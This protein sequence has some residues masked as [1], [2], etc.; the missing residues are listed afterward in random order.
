MSVFPLLPPFPPVQCSLRRRVNTMGKILLAIV[1]LL[2]LAAGA[3]ADRI[4]LL[5]GA[6]VEGEIVDRDDKH[7]TVRVTVG[8]RVATRKFPVERIHAITQEEKREVLNEMPEGE[9]KTAPRGTS[10]KSKTKSAGDHAPRTKAQIEALIQQEGTTPPDWWESTPLEYPKTLD[11]S[12]AEPA[13][14]G[15]NSQR[16]IGQYLWDI[17]NPNSGKWRSGVRFMHHVLEVHKDNPQTRMRVMNSLGQ[18]Y[19]RL[20]QDYPRAA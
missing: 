8:S 16:N 17:I 7:V 4:E 9:A 12:F 14:G 15:W 20:L 2:E 11:L 1:I 18:M 6:S 13:P 5:S 19:C 3:W 10:S